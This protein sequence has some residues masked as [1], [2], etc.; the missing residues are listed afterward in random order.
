MADTGPRLEERPCW[1]LSDSRTDWDERHWTDHDAALADLR[2]DSDPD[3][4][5]H[6]ELVAAPLPCRIARAACGYTFDED[7]DGV[8]HLPSDLEEAEEWLYD[9]QWVRLPDGQ[10]ACGGE[11]CTCVDLLGDAAKPRPRPARTGPKWTNDRL[12]GIDV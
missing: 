7:G 12:E 3:R 4:G 11:Q 2:R 9:A 8:C 1:I 6:L 5:R 10:W